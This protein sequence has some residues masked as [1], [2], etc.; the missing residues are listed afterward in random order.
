ML[1][2]LQTDRDHPAMMLLALQ[3]DRLRPAVPNLHCSAACSSGYRCTQH[4]LHPINEGD[5][6]SPDLLWDFP[7]P[8]RCSGCLC[9][10]IV[11]PLLSM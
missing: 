3:T 7:P 9:S 8:D 10:S 11:I 4:K 2:A 6:A 5:E 1:L